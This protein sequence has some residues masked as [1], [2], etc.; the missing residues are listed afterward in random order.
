MDLQGKSQWL[1]PV[2]VR[3][4]RGAIPRAAS[5]ALAA[6]LAPSSLMMTHDGSG[7]RP[8]DPPGLD[9]SW[10]DRDLRRQW[11]VA[12]SAGAVKLLVRQDGVYRVTAAQLYRAGLPA[13][14]P[15]S[16]VQLWAGGRLVAFRTTAAGDA[17]E[18]FGQAA[19]TRYTATRVYWVTKGLGSPVFIDEAPAASANITQTSFLETLEIP[20]ARS[21]SRR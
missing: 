12:N 18:F 20:T 2:N 3:R 11:D 4:T 9:R 13:G 21:T 7:A 10:R 15:M 8:V 5:A 14:T 1:G 17:L 16:A 6:P 19:D